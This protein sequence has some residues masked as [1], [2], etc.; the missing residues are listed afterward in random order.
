ML[1]KNVLLISTLAILFS[2]SLFG[3]EIAGVWRGTLTGGSKE[4]QV[5]VTIAKAGTDGWKATIQAGDNPAASG[6]V[7]SVK[8]DGSNLTLVVAGVGGTYEGRI[9]TNGSFCVGIWK[10]YRNEMPLV[11]RHGTE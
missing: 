3:H 2:G 8:L 9:S 5:V 10:R 4:L 1:R 7:T 6:D 11:F